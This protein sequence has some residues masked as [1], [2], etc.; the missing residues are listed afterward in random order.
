MV[1]YSSSASNSSIFIYLVIFYF[2]LVFLKSVF[3]SLCYQYPYVDVHHFISLTL[4]V[5][6]VSI[7][8]YLFSNDER[9]TALCAA[10]PETSN[11]QG[12]YL[13]LDELLVEN[14]IWVDEVESL[15][16]ATRHIEGFKVVGLDCEWKP[17]YVKGSKPN[18]VNDLPAFNSFQSIFLCLFKFFVNNYI[19]V[20][21]FRAV[22]FSN[23]KPNA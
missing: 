20:L 6:E 5:R 11:L 9:K 1:A 13:C 7:F 22:T 3:H 16:D 10:V 4:L 17:N 18:K 21:V 15:F 14:I 2:F 23:K 19:W 12:R 8:F